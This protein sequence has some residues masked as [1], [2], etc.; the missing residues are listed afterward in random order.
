MGGLVSN[1]L[2]N[3]LQRLAVCGMS[4]SAPAETKVEVSKGLKINIAKAQSA[5]QALFL[6]LPLRVYKQTAG[7]VFAELQYQVSDAQGRQALSQAVCFALADVRYGSQ[8]HAVVTY[9]TVWGC[10]S[11]ACLAQFQLS[12]A[13][14]ATPAA[15][16]HGAGV[17][18]LSILHLAPA[19]AAMNSHASLMPL[20][21]GTPVARETWRL[22]L[23]P[24]MQS[25]SIPIKHFS[26]LS[27]STSVVWCHLCLHRRE[28]ADLLLWWYRQYAL[29]LRRNVVRSA[30]LLLN[31]NKRLTLAASTAL[32]TGL[33]CR[34]A[35]LAEHR[36]GGAIVLDA[37]WRKAAGARGT[38]SAAICP[39]V[40]GGIPELHSEHSATSSP[41]P[42][43]RGRGGA[44]LW[45]GRQGFRA[46]RQGFPVVQRRRPNSPAGRLE[47][48]DAAG[49]DSGGG[50][51]EL[52]GA[53]SIRAGCWVPLACGGP[54][55]QMHIQRWLPAHL[56]L[57]ARFCRQG[58]AIACALARY[59][60]ITKKVLGA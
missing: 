20:L 12:Q 43:H 19:A 29:L 56:Q 14:E 15:L 42:V 36:R 57:D 4:A 59:P 46:Q 9:T 45:E 21:R 60:H 51:P 17:A 8:Q 33:T 52:P 50:G 38:P 24:G 41:R 28:S 55:W 25:A 53:V 31:S 26:T 34:A 44:G 49:K 11:R 6:G 48:G 30:T 10:S 1:S 40:T 13:L 54:G 5:R 32:H 3:F 22:K 18:G 27:Q 35:A 23:P 47:Q 37:D 58:T 39:D 16:R 7:R 2:I